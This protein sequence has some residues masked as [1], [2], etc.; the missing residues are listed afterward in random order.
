MKFGITLLVK[1]LGQRGKSKFEFA[2][3][4]AMM[5]GKVNL[6]LDNRLLNYTTE[7]TMLMNDKDL[8]HGAHEKDL[9]FF[10]FSLKEQ[11]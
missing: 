7:E 3:T 2:L 11:L 5:K 9:R 10:Q 1:D 4:L 8:W 6:Q